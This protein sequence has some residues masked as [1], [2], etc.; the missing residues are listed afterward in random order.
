MDLVEFQRHVRDGVLRLSC[1]STWL[2]LWAGA[3]LLMV[4]QDLASNFSRGKLWATFVLSAL[5]C[6]VYSWCRRTNS[7]PL[8]DMAAKTA[9]LAGFT[10]AQY[11]LAY[12]FLSPDRAHNMLVFVYFLLCCVAS[13]AFLI[14]IFTLLLCVG[15]KVRTEDEDEDEDEDE[16]E[17][18]NELGKPLLESV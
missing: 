11:T 9:S 18:K 8:I 5:V 3:I 17:Y 16:N 15:D 10:L 7:H 2:T 6:I 4:H 14:A 13:A 1:A 12:L